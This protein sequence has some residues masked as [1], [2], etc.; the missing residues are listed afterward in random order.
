MY[1]TAELELKYYDITEL[2]DLAEELLSTAESPYITDPEAQIN[3]VQ[4]L[5]EQVSESTDILTE[6]FTEVANQPK[7]V[8][9]RYQTKVEGALRRIYIAMDEYHKTIAGTAKEHT[10]A[11]RNIADPVVEKIRRQVE[12]IIA[13]FVDF[14][15]LSLDRI[16]QK[17][18]IEELKARQE[19]IASMLF[20]A[21]QMQRGG[22]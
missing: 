14:V 8:S 16:M 5:I 21:N 15:D 4:P 2:Y 11:L 7:N 17:S 13:V 19:K 3:L 20:H 18:H 6:A 1:S 22:V 9:K 10:R 12:T